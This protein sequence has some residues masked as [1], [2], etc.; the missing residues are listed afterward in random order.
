MGFGIAA[1]LFMTSCNLESVSKS[2]FEDKDV[3]SDPTLT[4]YAIY[5]IYEVFGHTNSHR[6]RYL[7]YYGY[8][9][10]I[11]WA[12]S[13]T[14]TNATT[15]VM[16]YNSSAN[17]ST[18]NV[19]GSPYDELFA[20]V[21]RANLCI[22]GIRAHGNIENNAEM[23]ALLG[24]ALCARALLYLELLKGYGE[25]PARFEPANSDNMYQNKADKDVIYK[26]ILAD[27]EESFDYMDYNT[28]TRTDK[29]GLAFAKGL[30]ARIALYASGY[31]QRPDEGAV[32][33]GD[34]GS[35]R[36]SN[37]PELQ[38]SVLYPKALTALKDV[39]DNSGLYLM[40]YKTM[41]W[42]QNNLNNL[43]YGPEVMFVI[44]FSNT[45]GRWNYTHAIRH[46]G[47]DVY[48]PTSS[49]RGGTS[50]AVPYVYYW[51]G[52]NDVRRDLSVVN[53]TWDPEVN[54][55]YPTPAGIANWYFAKYR[56]EWMQS[57]PYD[58]GNDDGI[59]P[60]Y[61]RYADVLLMAAEIANSSE[62]GNDQNYAKQCLKTV[63]ERAYANNPSEGD[64]E[65]DALSGQSEIFEYIKKQRAL[66]FVGEFLRKADLI[67]WNE[68]K[69]KM[70][71]A[72]DELLAMRTGGIGNITGFDYSQL[73]NEVNA[74]DSGPR[75]Y[76]WYYTYT[77]EDKLPN[78]YIYGIH[79]GE[80]ECSDDSTPPGSY[81][82][83]PFTNSDG[84][85]SSYISSSSFTSSSNSVDR[86]VK[87]TGGDLKGGFYDN[88]PDTR[89]YWPIPE[90]TITNAQG[91]L[92]ND[93][94]Y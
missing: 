9:T 43:S 71:D 36:L 31:S 38:K 7:P 32:G 78:V 20:G 72:A 60:V 58:G 53:Y 33:S 40:D 80:T 37:D 85:V 92:Q 44:P 90:I 87:G 25:V 13:N 48:N 35:V 49:S 66:E 11:E 3:Y 86:T 83:Q 93:Y 63:M 55:N 73:F 15:M 4:Q 82:W 84:E 47:Y 89:Q 42:N 1:A 74:N 94:G 59:K 28:T 17:N 29:I 8:N 39:I 51:Y 6:G 70:D 65:V 16:R 5:S 75:Q 54:S 91:S 76:I 14:T 23:A 67:R 52:E 18:M 69:T 10:D 79:P 30:Y 62:G 46:E 41:W 26:Q 21:E 57:Y 2:T 12:T 19:S 61:M 22:E 45:R 56:L 77:D 64:A 81:D 50:G 27:I 34:M 88:D 24:E 68:L